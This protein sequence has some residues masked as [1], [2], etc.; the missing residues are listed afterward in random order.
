MFVEMLKLYPHFHKKGLQGIETPQS[1]GNL[2][3]AISSVTFLRKG[4]TEA[5]TIIREFDKGKT[6]YNEI[7]E[8]LKSK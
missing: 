6:L 5:E 8:I 7:V 1:P 2:E 4:N 3:G